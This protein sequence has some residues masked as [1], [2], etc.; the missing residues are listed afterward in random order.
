MACLLSLLAAVAKSPFKKKLLLSNLL[1]MLLTTK[2]KKYSLMPLKAKA[3]LLKAML[4]K[5]MLLKVML[6]LKVTL[7][8]AKATLNKLSLY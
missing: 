6:P 7:P 3:M 4:L 5:V 1:T 2:H 8:K